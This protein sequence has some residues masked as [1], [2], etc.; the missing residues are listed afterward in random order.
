MSGLLTEV[1]RDAA[2]DRWIAFAAAKSLNV[3]AAVPRGEVPG[4]IYPAAL[5]LILGG[6]A[7]ISM[8]LKK[9]SGSLYSKRVLN[10]LL[11]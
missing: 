6:C 9:P 3:A 4:W 1:L 7:L 11:I 8:S 10:T 5:F 2:T